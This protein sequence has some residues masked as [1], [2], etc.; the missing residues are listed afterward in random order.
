M[1]RKLDF[2]SFQKSVELVN[3]NLLSSSSSSAESSI[4][5]NRRVKFE[6]DFTHST[7]VPLTHNIPGHVKT[8]ISSQKEIQSENNSQVQ[9]Q[10]EQEATTEI[11]AQSPKVRLEDSKNEVHENLNEEIEKISIPDKSVPE[12]EQVQETE[13]VQDTV[14]FQDAMKNHAKVC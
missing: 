13:K 3:F 10:K 7:R 1:R 11:T 9:V 8:A 6:S 12:V 5:G 14:K 4:L 2:W